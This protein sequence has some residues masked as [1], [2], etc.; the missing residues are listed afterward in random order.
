M[1]IEQPKNG[2]EEAMKSEPS[3]IGARNMMQIALTKRYCGGWEK[4]KMEQW[5]SQIL[6]PQ[7]HALVKRRT[8]LLVLYE[9]DPEAALAEAEKELQL[10]QE[11]EE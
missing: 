11:T 3:H 4:K 7:F 1:S 8:E 6:S 5:L 9:K 2:G 10:E